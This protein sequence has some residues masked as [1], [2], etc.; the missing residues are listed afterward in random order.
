MNISTNTL[1]NPTPNQSERAVNSDCEEEED[2][3]DEEIVN[4]TWCATTAGLRVIPF[5]K[6]NRVL[7]PIPGDGKPTEFFR[8]LFDEILYETIVRQTNK[9]AEKLKENHLVCINDDLFIRS[10]KFRTNILRDAGTKLYKSRL[11]RFFRDSWSPCP[12]SSIC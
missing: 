2:S 11:S 12:F 5:T 7:C 4:P 1:R 9:K 10:S 6:V 3:D 8:L